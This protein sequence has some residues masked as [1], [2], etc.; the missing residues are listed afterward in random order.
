MRESGAW[1]GREPDCDASGEFK[2]RQYDS[3]TKT[4]W[5]VD[6]AGKTISGPA[7]NRF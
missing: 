2:P 1:G 3:R 4:Y 7:T 6:R 5:C